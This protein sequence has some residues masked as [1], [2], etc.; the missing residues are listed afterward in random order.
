M[1]I[2]VGIAS[3]LIQDHDNNSYDHAVILYA[4]LAAGSAIV[5]SALVLLS[6]KTIDLGQ[7]Q[8][9]RKQRRA[10]GNVWNARKER[11]Q[12]DDWAKN[13][14]LSKGCFG[15]LMVLVVASW[16]VFFWGVATGRSD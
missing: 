3:G 7:L 10:K 2:I 11:F 15:A 16:C 13:K 9:T 6:F 8:W 12:I 1:N 14:L 5:G 4:T